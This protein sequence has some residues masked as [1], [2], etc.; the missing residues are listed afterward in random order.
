[1]YLEE[2]MRL[3]ETKDVDV[4]GLHVGTQEADKAFSLS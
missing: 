2:I 1:M 3:K 4:G